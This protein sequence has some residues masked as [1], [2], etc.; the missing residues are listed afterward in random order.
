MSN[1]S[2]FTLSL[3]DFNNVGYIQ[4]HPGLYINPSLKDKMEDKVFHY[5]RLDYLLEMLQS[6][7]LYVS[8]RSQFSDKREI[9]S[10][11]D[12]HL[13]FHLFPVYRSESEQEKSNELLLKKIQSAYSVCI[14]CWTF[15][16]H[17]NT[18]ENY[19]SWRCYG[20]NLCRVESTLSDL[21]DSIVV[22]DNT[23]LISSVQYKQDKTDYAAQD[24]I[25][26][27][28]YAYQY[29]QELRIALLSTAS[30]IRLEVNL[31]RLIHKIRLSPFFSQRMCN[32]IKDTLEK[33]YSLS[34]KIEKSHI[35]E[36]S[37]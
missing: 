10:K 15:D 33:D 1:K 24:L 25:F 8:N 3:K 28:H 11:E 20:D 18:D 5:F 19:M 4:H 6:H 14:S 36:N 21:I 9:G 34:G 16:K 32:M 35:L 27:K 30:N 22:G 13:T 12:F 29:E 17:P 37:R 26:S 23:I 31:E 7:R 2:D